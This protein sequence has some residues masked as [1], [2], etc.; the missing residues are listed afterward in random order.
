V[1]K[2]GIILLFLLV[3]SFSLLFGQEI[4][5]ADRYMELVSNRYAGIRDYEAN[6]EIRSGNHTMSGVVSYLTPSFIR[7]DFT[8]PA[9]QVIVFNGDALTIYLPDSRAVLNQPVA[10]NRRG[11]TAGA[12][13][14]GLSMLRRNYVASFVSGPHPEPLDGGG[15][16]VM[17][18]RLTRRT[19]SEGFREIILTVNAD[20]RLIRRMEGTTLA[21]TIVRFD[22]TNIR[23]NLGV[24]EQRFAYDT[25]PAAS[26]F[27]N[28]LFRDSD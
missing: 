5:T 25:P 2:R 16:R 23:T 20:T 12:G 9:E 13:S 6:I 3:F 18:L 22:F 14:S 7:I 15:E 4:H 26:M 21:E 19:S 24:P 8:R 27:N 17:R 1:K 10:Q 28:F 11:M